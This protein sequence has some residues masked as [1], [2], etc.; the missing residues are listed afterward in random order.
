MASPFVRQTVQRQHDIGGG[1]DVPAAG[2][3][4]VSRPARCGRMQVPAINQAVTPCRVRLGRRGQ[5][6]A[7]ECGGRWIKA[8][9][10][11]ESALRPR[12]IKMTDQERCEPA[13]SVQLVL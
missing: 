2:D 10:L 13:T 1:V 12:E 5:E 11:R 3:V 7:N 4:G 9:C 8:H 6:I